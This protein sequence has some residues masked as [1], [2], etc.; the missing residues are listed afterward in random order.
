MS[1]IC[2]TSVLFC[3]VLS[4]PVSQSISLCFNFGY[5]LYII[6]SVQKALGHCA[7]PNGASVR[8]VYVFFLKVVLGH[9]RPGGSPDPSVCPTE[10]TQRLSWD[11]GTL[12][13][14]LTHHGIK[15]VSQSAV[16]LLVAAATGAD[17]HPQVLH[18]KFHF[19]NLSK[20]KSQ[21][22]EKL[23]KISQNILKLKSEK[24]ADSRCTRS[25]E[26]TQVASFYFFVHLLKK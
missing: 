20:K 23:G 11:G 13:Y 6:A 1:K 15:I 3:M 2:D 18:E 10:E 24:W 21:S 22:I 16:E 25:P 26:K 12:L 5:M 4:C 19:Q 7:P 8:S 9:K 17:P 14:A